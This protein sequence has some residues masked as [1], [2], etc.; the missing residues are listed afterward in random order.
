MSEGNLLHNDL[1]LAYYI[2]VKREH[3]ECS[4]FEFEMS[5][6]LISEYLFLLIFLACLDHHN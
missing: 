6:F 3:L 5:L 4:Q 2:F 1:A